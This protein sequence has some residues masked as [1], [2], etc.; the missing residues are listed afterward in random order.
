MKKDKTPIFNE[1]WV[2]RNKVNN[3]LNEIDIYG[4]NMTY[5]DDLLSIKLHIFGHIGKYGLTN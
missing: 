2:K 3:T 1:D 4:T 5:N